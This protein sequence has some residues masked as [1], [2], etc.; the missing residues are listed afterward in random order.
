MQKSAIPT[1]LYSLARVFRDAGAVLYAVGGMVRNACLGLPVQDVD[2]ASPLPVAE[3]RA[4]LEA[5]GIACREKGSFFG[6]LDVALGEHTFEYAAFRAEE[7]GPGG[8]HRPGVVRFGATLAEDAFR[9]DF[10]VNALYY[11]ILGETIID[12]T[13]GVKDLSARLIRATSPDPG[14]ILRDDGLRIL[15]MARFAAE[16]GF[17]VEAGT[18]AAAGANAAGVGDISPE[19][20]RDELDRILLADIPYGRGPGQVFRG[21]S[22]LLECGALAAFLPEV[23]AGAGVAQRAEYHAYDVAEHMLRTCA[24]AKPQRTARLAA[25]L[26]DV[27]KPVALKETGRMLGHDACGADISREIMARLRYPS[28]TRAEV[29][30]LVRAHMYDLNGNARESTLRRR[31]ALWGRAFT[32]ALADLREADVHG[33]GRISGPVRSA[34]RWRAVLAGMEA[35]GAPL[36]PKELRCTGADIMEWLGIPPSPRVGA[37]KEKL[38]M[39]CACHPRDN[40]PERLR[41]IARDIG[42]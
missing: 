18:M 16:L 23:A 38:L 21:L 17:S 10:T 8:A 26:H 31:F 33:S 29:S 7:Y 42:R 4:L 22:I 27:G 11:D 3:A 36:S 12:P 1:E 24:A 25:L 34:E 14:V 40:C 35:E 9:R 2:V 37:V 30:A 20:I 32:L 39:H 6:T 41:R 5:R 13:G 28:E 19:R 15:R